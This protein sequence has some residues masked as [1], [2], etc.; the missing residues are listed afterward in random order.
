MKA[1]N[2]IMSG[3]GILMDEYIAII[4]NINSNE[5][6]YDELFG[7]DYS[8]QTVFYYEDVDSVIEGVA[9]RGIP[10]SLILIDAV[11]KLENVPK[12]FEEIKNTYLFVFIPIIITGP[13]DDIKYEKQCFLEWGVVDYVPYSTIESLL[14]LHANVHIERFKWAFI[15]SM[16]E[17]YTRIY[18]RRYYEEIKNRVFQYCAGFPISLCMI[19]I[20][21][22]KQFNDNYGHLVFCK[23]QISK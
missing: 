17:I 22:F 3:R 5:K 14:S 1:W 13:D 12:I 7:I 15:D 16:T 9:E 20:D 10:P 19:D 2:Y 23:K 8:E 4:T 11:K 6:K 21:Y 18:N